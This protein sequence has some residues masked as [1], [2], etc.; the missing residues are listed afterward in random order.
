MQAGCGWVPWIR[1]DEG[2]PRKVFNSTTGGQFRDTCCEQIA[3][4][5]VNQ[6]IGLHVRHR[7]DKNPSIKRVDNTENCRDCRENHGNSIYRGCS[8][9]LN[10]EAAVNLSTQFATNQ[11]SGWK[12]PLFIN[13][14]FLRQCTLILVFLLVHRVLPTD[15]SRSS[16][17]CSRFPMR[18]PRNVTVLLIVIMPGAKRNLDLVL[19]VPLC[20]RNRTAERD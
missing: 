18:R 5:L 7:S 14:F 3:T 8:F 13:Q 16:I 1:L 19:H 17:D 10:T 20:S 15:W 4:G 2:G 11:V 9:L 6:A 12:G